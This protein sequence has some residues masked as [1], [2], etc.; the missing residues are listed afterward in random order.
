MK[1]PMRYEPDIPAIIHPIISPRFSTGNNSDANVRAIVVV[2]AYPMP[3]KENEA[4]IE[5]KLG[6]IKQP[7]AETLYDN[8]PIW[9]NSL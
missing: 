3:V 2:K 9:S 1:A 6:A 5:M 7:M 4:T 8:K